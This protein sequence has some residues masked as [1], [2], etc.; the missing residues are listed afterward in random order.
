MPRRNRNAGELDEPR[1]EPN[2]SA[3]INEMRRNTLTQ[4]SE[5][6]RRHGGITTTTPSKHI[7]QA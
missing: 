1:G 3:L 5:Q 7:S 2:Y 6:A 4:P